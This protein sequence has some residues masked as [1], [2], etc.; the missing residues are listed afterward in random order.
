MGTSLIST[1]I[2]CIMA[3]IITAMIIVVV[4]PIQNKHIKGDVKLS[5]KLKLINQLGNG[6]SVLF[7]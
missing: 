4:S 5:S 7:H 2:Y 3:I 6:R 1:I